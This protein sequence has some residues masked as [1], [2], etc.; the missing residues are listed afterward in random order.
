MKGPFWVVL[1]FGRAKW[2]SIK[3]EMGLN[4]KIEDKKVR[5]YEINQGGNGPKA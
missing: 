5:M 4:Q 3:G 1:V 2:T